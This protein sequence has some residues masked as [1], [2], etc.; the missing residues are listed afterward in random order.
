[1]LPPPLR[2]HPGNPGVGGQGGTGGPGGKI[3][4]TGVSA[5]GTYITCGGNGQDGG[6]GGTQ[7][8]AGG[9]GGAA[10]TTGGYSINSVWTFPS[11]P[12]HTGITGSVG[13]PA[14]DCDCS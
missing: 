4:L 1:V 3:L 9:L 5:G 2:P 7:A 10:G 8:G 14:P 6:P 11:C 12:L 13:G